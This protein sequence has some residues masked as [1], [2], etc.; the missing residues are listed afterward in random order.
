[1]WCV[2]CI[3]IYI[4]SATIKSANIAKKI[5]KLLLI[6]SAQIR[7]AATMADRRARRAGYPENLSIHSYGTDFSAPG[8]FISLIFPLSCYLIV[9][10]SICLQVSLSIPSI[11]LYSLCLSIPLSISLSPG[12]FISL[13]FPLSLSI[14]LFIYLSPGI[15]LSPI[16]SLSFYLYLSI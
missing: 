13:L 16:P 15:Y 6:F 1:M 2:I 10:I 9:Y 3:Q 11:V 4:W 7:P 5:R 12:I 8:I 14:S